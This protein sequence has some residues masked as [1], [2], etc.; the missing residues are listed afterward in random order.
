[1]RKITEILLT[2]E[3]DQHTNSEDIAKDSGYNVNTYR[4]LVEQVAQLA[5][6]NKD[7]LLF[8]RGQDKDYTNRV[9]KSTF[10][11][12]IYRPAV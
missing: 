1:M 3:L 12:T 10:Y 2:K 5:Y 4:K 11:P 9:G 8:F 7:Y 6:L